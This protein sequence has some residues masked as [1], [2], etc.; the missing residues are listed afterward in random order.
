MIV[1]DRCRSQCPVSYVV[2]M[3][4]THTHKFCVFF[5][6]ASDEVE[7]NAPIFFFAV[8][9]YGEKKTR[10]NFFGLRRKMLRAQNRVLGCATAV[11]QNGYLVA[12]FYCSA[13]IYGNICP[14]TLYESDT[15]NL[16]E[17]RMTHTGYQIRERYVLRSTI[18]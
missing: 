15:Y 4:H 7:K 11:A 5:L 1:G 16:Y 9:G 14:G 13:N 10:N 3:L 17:V 18:F 8:D 6:N 2:S 12:E